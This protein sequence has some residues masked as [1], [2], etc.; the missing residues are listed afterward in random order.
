MW[1]KTCRKLI[2]ALI[3]S[4]KRKCSVKL[5]SPIKETDR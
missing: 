1:G 3:E 2:Q 5:V 4:K